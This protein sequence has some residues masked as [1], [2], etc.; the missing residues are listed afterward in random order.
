MGQKR[1]GA[2]PQY[3]GPDDRENVRLVTSSTGAILDHNYYKAFLEMLNVIRRRE[4][5]LRQLRSK[6]TRNSQ[7]F[8]LVNPSEIK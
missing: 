2:S 3:F 4:L 1:A 7:P 8:P 6:F 5:A